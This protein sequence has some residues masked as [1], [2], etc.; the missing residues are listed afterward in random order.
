MIRILRPGSNLQGPSQTSAEVALIFHEVPRQ[1]EIGDLRPEPLVQQYV[2][3][4]DVPVNDP[5][6][7][8]VVQVGKALRR[9]EDDLEPP[10]PIQCVLLERVCIAIARTEVIQRYAPT[11]FQVRRRFREGYSGLPNR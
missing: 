7:R 5:D 6:L 2:A 4:L 3:G 9:P 11:R 1:A 8:S 10:L